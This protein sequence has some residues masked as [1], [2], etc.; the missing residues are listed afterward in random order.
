MSNTTSNLGRTTTATRAIERSL[1]ILRNRRSV[2]N[3]KAP[4]PRA[5]ILIVSQAAP[6]TEEEI[7]GCHIE[8]AQR[9]S[10][11]R[12]FQVGFTMPNKLG[13]TSLG[14]F[15]ESWTLAG[16]NCCAEIEPGVPCFLKTWEQVPSFMHLGKELCRLCGDPHLIGYISKCRGPRRVS[17]F[18]LNRAAWGYLVEAA[19]KTLCGDKTYL[20]FEVA[21]F[22]AELEIQFDLRYGDAVKFSMTN[23]KFTYGELI[24][25]RGWR[26][27]LPN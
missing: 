16:P 2:A 4:H 23:G 15:L 3:S 5:H 20:P 6:E 12:P 17:T 19:E 25:A 7:Y 27:A 22:I 10:V 21:R 1:E 8:H 13:G 9:S 11:N 18:M 14:C 24:F 26:D